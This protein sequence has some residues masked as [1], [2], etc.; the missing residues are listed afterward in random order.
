MQMLV[1]VFHYILKHQIF[2][3]G[4]EKWQEVRSEEMSIHLLLFFYS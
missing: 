2:L 1:F 4:S 3:F